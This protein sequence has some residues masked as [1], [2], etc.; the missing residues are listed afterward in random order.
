MA[1]RRGVHQ[2]PAPM[3]LR[4]LI[5][6]GVALTLADASIVTLALPPMLIDLDTTVEGVAAV[7]G[8]YTLVLAA[9]LP[10]A[11]WLRGRVGDRALG[12]AGFA[13]FAVASALCALPDA[14]GGMLA[15]R[16]VQAA[17][18]AAGLVAAFA[19]LGGG[20]LWIAA[21]VF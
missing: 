19:F 8:V 1:R 17:G 5:A 12:A 15:L 18:A 20:R 14:L 6:A 9:G 13:L 3:P 2:D 11:A 7:I 10:L 4:L 21:A 16:A